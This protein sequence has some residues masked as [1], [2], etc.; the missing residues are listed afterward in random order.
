MPGDN[1][2]QSHIANEYKESNLQIAERVHIED[3]G[4]GHRKQEILGHAG[5]DMPWVGLV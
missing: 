1:E 3:V 5:E 2:G 4:E